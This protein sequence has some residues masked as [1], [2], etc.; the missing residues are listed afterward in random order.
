MFKQRK[1]RKEKTEKKL[2]I[3]FF[4]KS[5]LFSKEKLLLTFL[6]PVN[7]FENLFRIFGKK[8]IFYHSILITIY[9]S[10]KS[11]CTEKNYSIFD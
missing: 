8:T 6:N 11:T 1:E 2:Q 3:S 9:C 7:S 10:L 5:T 4:L